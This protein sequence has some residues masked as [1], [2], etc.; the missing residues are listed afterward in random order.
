MEGCVREESLVYS[1]YIDFAGRPRPSS[2]VHSH[3]RIPP[4]NFVSR[5][6]PPV[7]TIKEKKMDFNIVQ[8]ELLAYLAAQTG[9]S[10]LPELRFLDKRGRKELSRLVHEVPLESVSFRDWNDAL[11][12]LCQIPPASSAAEAKEK[13][14]HFLE[15]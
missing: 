1:R 13:L 12:Y 8:G 14:L 2:V 4:V 7:A 6:F 11:E 10:I 5:K 3:N 15:S 9:H